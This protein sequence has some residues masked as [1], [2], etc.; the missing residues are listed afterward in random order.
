MTKLECNRPTGLLAAWTVSVFLASPLAGKETAATPDIVVYGATPAGIAAAVGAAREGKA[1]TLVEPLPQAGGVMSGGLSFSDSNQTAREALGGIF[2]EFH[3]KVEK[4]YHDQGTTLP[5]SVKLKDNRPWTYEP[6]VAEKIF[7]E[8]LT[9]A[10]V[11]LRL[12]ETLTTAICEAGRIKEIRTDKGQQYP[13]KV[14]VD[15][16]YE[17]DLMAAAGVSYRVGREGRDEFDEPLAGARYPKK[18]IENV[19]VLDD[20]GKPLPLITATDKTPEGQGDKRIM[21]YSF[22]F[23]FSRDPEN[24]VPF[25]KPEWYDA[26]RY[27]LFGRYLEA[28]P[29]LRKAFDL[30]VLPNN[31]LDGNNGIGLQM[32]LGLVDENAEYPD[33]TPQR[34]REIWQKHR[35]YSE[36]LF[37]FLKTDKRVPAE[38][39]RVMSRIGY[40]KDEFVKFGHFPPVLYVREARRMEGAYFLTEHDILTSITKTDSIG[41]GSFP[42]DSHD[43]Q[44][45][46]LGDGGFITEGTIFPKRLKPREIGQPHQL[47]YRAITPRAEQC[48][49]LLVPVCLSASHVALSSVRVEPTWIVLGHSA[50]IAAALAVEENKAVQKLDYPALAAR[51]KKQGQILDMD[52]IDFNRPARTEK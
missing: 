39:Q 30:Y 11:T 19:K 17:G 1:V 7:N 40:A 33:A 14:F 43:C 49:N 20:A 50:G 31:K 34:R 15:A 35:L 42:I 51:L 29:D 12:E 36:G 26:A 5:Y 6:H 45:I 16:S 21:T 25:R 52:G 23:C 47:P 37:Y 18:P 9:E 46:A 44:R 4:H 41:V 10:G 32:S 3:L 27:E 28:H 38:I 13:A 24:Q 48:S 22:R 8:M 2:E